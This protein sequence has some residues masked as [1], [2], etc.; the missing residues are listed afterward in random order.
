MAKLIK[1]LIIIIIAVAAAIAVTSLNKAVEK[2][3]LEQ[4]P[5]NREVI[6]KYES[7]ELGLSFEYQKEPDGYTLV[8]KGGEEAGDTAIVRS[9]VLM[10]TKGY[11]E[12]LASGIPTEGPPTMSVTVFENSDNLS[13]REWAETFSRFSLL[14]LALSPITET[15]VAGKQAITYKADG[16]YPMD[17][18]IVTNNGKAYVIS[19]GYLALEDQIRNDFEKF[20][21][22]I[23]FF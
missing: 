14:E 4:E 18:Y 21:E 16:L 20:L 8:E 19:G 13:P 23:K 10:N 7:E 6:E 15:S 2:P 11:A 9:V 17:M 22:S 3:T 12:V 1:N 5:E